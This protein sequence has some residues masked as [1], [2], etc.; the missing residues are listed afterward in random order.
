MKEIKSKF[1]TD[2]E[3]KKIKNNMRDKEQVLMFNSAE[4]GLIKAVF[5]DNDDLLY[6]IRKVFLQFELD[7]NESA[8][9]K[10][11][12]T[13][14]LYSILKKRIFPDW[15]CEYPLTQIPSFLTPLTT[16]IR[17]RKEEDMYSLFEAKELEMDYLDQQFRVLKG[18]E[19]EQ[20]IIL[21]DLARLKGKEAHQK[22][23]DMT[24]YLYLMGHIDPMLGFLKN[25]AG[26]KIETV[27]E[28]KKRMLRDSS[29]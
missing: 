5:A 3:V 2:E 23:I 15:G 14:E 20:K 22:F 25:I 11:S 7:K 6:I 19:V 26:Q 8:T 10:S 16:D 24:A 21:I 28:A 27:E 18:E 9:L 1:I 17:G 4:I 12:L 29:K 13:P